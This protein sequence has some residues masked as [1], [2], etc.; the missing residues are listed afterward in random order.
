[1]HK[2]GYYYL[3]LGKQ[4]ALQISSATNKFRYTTNDRKLNLPNMESISNLFSQIP[5][6]DN[7]SNLS[8]FEKVR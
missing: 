5:P 8:H 7:N 6:F 3:P 2:L 1:M 4:I